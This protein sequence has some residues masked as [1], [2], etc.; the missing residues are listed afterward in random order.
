M[1]PFSWLK[2]RIHQTP[3]PKA[4][5][6]EDHLDDKRPLQTPPGSEKLMNNLVITQQTLEDITGVDLGLLQDLITETKTFAKELETLENTVKQQGSTTQSLDIYNGSVEDAYNILQNT[7]GQSP[8]VIIRRFYLGRK[9]RVPALLVFNDGLADNQMVDQDIIFLMQRYQD[10]EELWE[11][12]PKIHQYVHDSI[13]SVGHV[14]VENRWTKLLP[15]MMGGNTL[16][17]I[18]GA[19]QVLVLD[20]VKYPARAIETPNTERAVKGPQE[21]FNEV[22]L[23]Q[24]NLIR[25]RIKSPALHF[26]PLSIGSYTKTVVIIAHIEGITNPELVMSV[27]RRLRGV[28]LDGLQYSNALVPYLTTHPLSLFPQVRSTERVDIIV[29]DLLLGKVAILVDNTPYP[30]TVPSTFMD[31]YQTTDD[32]T[33]NFWEASLERLVRLFGLFVGLLLP[34]FYVAFVSV[35]PDLLPLKL[36]ITIAGSRESVPFPPVLEVLI[37]WIIVEVLREAAIRLPKE[38]STTL[39]TVGAIVVGTAIVKAGIVDSIMIVIITL[40]ALG[41]FTS[42]VYEMATPWRILFWVLVFAAY[43]LGLYGMVLAIMMILAHLTS[44]ENFG[45]AYLSP[46]GPMRLR[47]LQDSWI[48]LPLSLLKKRPSYLRPVKTRKMGSNIPKPMKNPQL[49]STQQDRVDDDV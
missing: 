15:D 22:V 40:T 30:L 13:V 25:R 16:V 43:F 24:M 12:G 32:Y 28:K 10:A 23:T 48:R 26:D 3:A 20:T 36:V 11:N 49:Y 42:P 14:T 38:L 44:L 34:P 8:D 27:K 4:P 45:V 41:L 31:F 46:F 6:I 19:S 47:D 2:R 1:W 7:V 21:S 37:M 9:H 39:G 29:R 35:N 18:Q 5:V 17:F 33:G